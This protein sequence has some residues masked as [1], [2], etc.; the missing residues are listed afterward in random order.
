[1]LVRA[2]MVL[3]PRVEPGPAGL[4]RLSRGTA[5]SNVR[6]KAELRSSAL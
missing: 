5:C 6:E 3:E 4:S 2:L 1:M